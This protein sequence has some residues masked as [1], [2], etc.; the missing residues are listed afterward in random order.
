MPPIPSTSFDHEASSPN[1][2]AVTNKGASALGEGQRGLALIV[3]DEPTN[4]RLLTQMLR[5][6]GF[7][8]LEAATGEQAIE[9]FTSQPVDIIFMDVMMPGMDGFETTKRIKTLAGDNFVPVIFLTALRDE[10]SLIQ[11]TDAGGD[12]FLSKPFSLGILRARIIAMERVRNLHRTIASKT[13]ALA[14]LLEQDREEQELAE[15]VFNRAVNTSNVRLDAISLMQ[16]PATTFSGDL[17][18][19]QYLP[20]GGLRVLVGDFT[21][22]GLAAAI[23]ALPV[24]EV[25]HAMTRKGSDDHDI[26]V[27]MNRKLYQMLPAD[28]FMAACL[29]SISLAGDELRWWNGGM[30]SMWLRTAQ[31][32]IEL[33][34]HGLPLGILPKLPEREEQRVIMVT[35]QD[36]LLLMSDGL[37]EACNDDEQMFVDHGFKSTLENW[38][39]GTPVIKTLTDQLEQHVAGT[40]QADDIAIVEIPLGTTL[41]ANAQLTTEQHSRAGW[42]WTIEL[43][44]DRLGT[45]SSIHEALAPLRLWKGLEH[46]LGT[47]QTIITE[48]YANAL[49]HGILRLDSRMKATPEGFDAYYQQ[50]AQLLETC[51]GQ[52]TLSLDYQPEAEFGG[53]ITIHIKDSGQGFDECAANRD[54]EEKQ[55]CPWGRGIA[56]VRELCESVRYSDNGTKVEAVYRWTNT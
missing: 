16:R 46:H 53:A 47:L 37:L 30:P 41:F 40:E 50:R 49:E 15:R 12:D 27:E 55:L 6:E 7:A 19:T 43:R 11:C 44:N 51:Q 22:H 34:S 1:E 54:G 39:H 2:V 13:A 10:Q 23:G 24:S 8:T 3:D 42:R 48:L 5:R 14:T 45:L 21:G 32:L 29:V 4:R 33:P 38:Q 36:R 52:I 18:L 35:E 26:L 9:T 28:R 56:L 31:G 17:V 25:F 20:G